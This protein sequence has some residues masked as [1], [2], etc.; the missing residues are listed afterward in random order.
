[1]NRK[2]REKDSQASVKTS[3]IPF[4]SHSVATLSKV[5]HADTSSDFSEGT[6]WMTDRSVFSESSSSVAPSWTLG[7]GF[8]RIRMEVRVGKEFGG[9]LGQK[10]D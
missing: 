6:C 8:G 1:M 3:S 2:K 10:Y 9:G 7:A 4:A 5:Q